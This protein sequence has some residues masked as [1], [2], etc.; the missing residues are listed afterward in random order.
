MH[1]VFGE[2]IDESINIIEKGLL[3]KDV[4]VKLREFWVNNNWAILC[5]L[6]SDEE[7]KIIF[8]SEFERENTYSFLL[9]CEYFLNP[10][11][12]F[13]RHKNRNSHFKCKEYSKYS[14]FENIILKRIESLIS[15]VNDTLM[16][17]EKIELIEGKLFKENKYD[18]ESLVFSS[19][20]YDIGSFMLGC[21]TCK[22]LIC[23]KTVKNRII[24]Y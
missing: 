7:E 23:C 6:S 19:D 1:D 2:D 14:F 4:N 3:V 13:K 20:I 21:A 9:G 17:E 12:Y 18:V 11:D 15:D 22:E 10:I 24:L 16:L 5:K 8:Y